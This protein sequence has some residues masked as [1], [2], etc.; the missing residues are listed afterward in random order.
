MPRPSGRRCTGLSVKPGNGCETMPFRVR[1]VVLQANMFI[2]MSGRSNRWSLSRRR[3]RR[4][5]RCRTSV[6]CG[7]ARTAPRRRCGAAGCAASS[8]RVI[9]L[10]ALVG[11]VGVEVVV[12]VV[13]DRQVAYARDAHRLQVR[14]GSDAGQQQQLRRAVDAAGDDDLAACARGLAAR[15]GV[16]FDADRAAVL[17]QQA[18]GVRLGLHHEVRAACGPGRDRRRRCSSGGRCWSWSGRSRRPPVSRR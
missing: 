12:Q 4:R 17:D 15:R 18:G 3:R 1:S 13:A 5:G 6:P 8:F 9:G 14:G 11:Q 7:T 16:V 2:W 10:R